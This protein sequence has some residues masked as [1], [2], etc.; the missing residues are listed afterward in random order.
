MELQDVHPRGASTRTGLGGLLAEECH[1]C[2]QRAFILRF[3][4]VEMV[5]GLLGSSWRTHCWAQESWEVVRGGGIDA[6]AGGGR[7]LA[8]F[9]QFLGALGHQ[10]RI[11]VQLR[12]CLTFEMPSPTT[13]SILDSADLSHN[14]ACLPS[15]CRA[16]GGIPTSAWRLCIGVAL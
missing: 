3:A 6:G 11:G 5:A 8:G 7:G 13:L 9:C 15:M 4:L 2:S 12:K 14:L 16:S 1:C 10:G